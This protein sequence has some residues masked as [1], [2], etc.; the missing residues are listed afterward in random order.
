MTNDFVAE[1]WCCMALLVFELLETMH[2]FCSMPQVQRS[3]HADNL[4]EN[5]NVTLSPALDCYAIVRD[6]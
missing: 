4:T 6:W 5:E 3:F 2:L 1:G